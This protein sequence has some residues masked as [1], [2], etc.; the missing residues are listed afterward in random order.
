MFAFVSSF[1]SIRWRP[2]F[3]VVCELFKREENLKIAAPIVC[4][5]KLQL[6]ITA[7]KLHFSECKASLHMTKRNNKIRR[8]T[9]AISLQR[10]SWRNY[11]HLKLIFS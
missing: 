6:Q 9:F 1:N 3:S 10:A 7:S 8:K 11:R 4:R 2:D 5:L